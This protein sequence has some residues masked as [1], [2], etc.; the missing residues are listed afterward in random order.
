MIDALEL[1]QLSKIHTLHLQVNFQ[2]FSTLK[3]TIIDFENQYNIFSNSNMLS[4]NIDNH[5]T[6]NIVIMQIKISTSWAQLSWMTMLLI[7][8]DKD[9][10]AYQRHP[11]NLG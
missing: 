7:G 11:S 8:L 6:V 2:T 9:F 10:Q 4:S 3:V 1:Q 5:F